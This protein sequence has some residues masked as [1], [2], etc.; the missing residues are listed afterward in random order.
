M[1]TVRIFISSPGDVR[2]E[3]EKA[4]KIIARLEER[5]AG[6]AVLRSVL[7]EDLPLQADVS[8]QQGIDVVLSDAQ[9]IDIAVFILWSRLGT[10]TGALIQKPD[11]GQYSIAPTEHGDYMVQPGTY[12]LRILIPISAGEDYVCIAKGSEAVQE[13]TLKLCDEINNEVQY[14]S[15]MHLHNFAMAGH[16]ALYDGTLQIYVTTT[17]DRDDQNVTVQIGRRNAITG[18][19]PLI[20]TQKSKD[21]DVGVLV[22]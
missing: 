11:G 15:A 21:V 18:K 13:T 14:R 5:Y 2:E 22:P 1:K 10:P 20:P 16:K 17:T 12:T 4:R 8:F 19:R 7:W 3:R 9:G 6:Q